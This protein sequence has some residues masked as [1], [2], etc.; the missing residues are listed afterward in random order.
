MPIVPN[1]NNFARWLGISRQ[2]I[3]NS[4]VRG[5]D[6]AAYKYKQM[7]ADVLSEG[8]MVGV[9][10]ASSTQFTLKN[11]CDWADKYEDKGNDKGS[12]LAIE[13]AVNMMEQLGYAR[14]RSTIP[15]NTKLLEGETDG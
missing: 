14:E 7:L 11:L 8:A 13:D 9:Y 15:S 3:T 6:S 12:V 10:Q 2:I 4:M 1:Q 5:D